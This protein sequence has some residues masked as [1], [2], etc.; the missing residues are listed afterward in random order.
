[1][2]EL[3]NPSVEDLIYD[4]QCDRRVFLANYLLVNFMETTGVP[5]NA[6]MGFLIA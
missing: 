3:M 1:M 6:L 4:A 2:N 5:M